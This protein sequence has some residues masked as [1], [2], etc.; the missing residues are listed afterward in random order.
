MGETGQ[1]TSNICIPDAQAFLLVYPAT[2]FKK[3]L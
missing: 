1:G 3:A 2:Y